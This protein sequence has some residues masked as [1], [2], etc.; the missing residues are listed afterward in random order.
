[1]FPSTD[2]RLMCQKS[3]LNYVISKRIS[4]YQSHTFQV[5]QTV[6]N[7]S[8][9]I[10]KAQR[11]LFVFISVSIF[12]SNFVAYLKKETKNVIEDV[13]WQ[14]NQ[15]VL[16][17]RLIIKPY[18]FF[19]NTNIFFNTKQPQSRLPTVRWMLSQMRFQNNDKINRQSMSIKN[20]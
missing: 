5:E 15:K 9:F 3:Q 4:V 14:N 17:C 6:G 11:Q 1:M 12:R 2:N 16:G 18:K 13:N 8:M 20:N 7:V 19:G 10:N